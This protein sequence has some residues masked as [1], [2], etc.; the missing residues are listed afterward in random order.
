[1]FPL[2][3]TTNT[4]IMYGEGMNIKNNNIGM[5]SRLTDRLVADPFNLI[6]ILSGMFIKKVIRMHHCTL[7]IGFSHAS[8]V[9]Y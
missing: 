3:N 8:V 9:V 2:L 7:L 4:D 6:A 5:P 1:M